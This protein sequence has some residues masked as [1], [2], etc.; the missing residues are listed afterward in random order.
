M[1]FNKYDMAINIDIITIKKSNYYLV[2]DLIVNCPI[3]FKKCRNGREM[4]SKNNVNKKY[5]VYAANKNGKWTITDGSSKKCDKVLL[6]QSWVE[7]NIPEFSNDVKYDIEMAPDIIDLED[8]EKFQDDEGN[9]V[10]IEVRGDRDFDKCYFLVK[11]VANGFG[12]KRLHNVLIDDKQG[13]YIIKSHY[14]YFNCEVDSS[15]VKK[16]IKKELFL[17]YTGILRVLFTSRNKTTEKF[18]TWATKTLFTIQMGTK[19]QKNELIADIMGVSPE[20]V[21]AV[22]SKSAST[23]PCIYLFTIGTVKNLRKTLDLDDDYHDNDCVYRFGTTK[24][25]SRRTAE[26]TSSY[27]KL[28][29]AD[30]KLKIFNFIDVQYIFKAETELKLFMTTLNMNIKYENHKELVIIPKNKLKLV[31]KQYNYIGNNYIGHIKELIDKIKEKDSLIKDKD[32]E[33]KDKD[34][35]LKDKDHE[36]ELFK[37]K[38]ENKLLKKELEIVKLQSKL[39]KINLK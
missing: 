21:K 35:E 2:D 27:N 19:T 28:K 10:E 32:H 3:F 18:I 34:H 1:I 30:V 33:L 6:L 5:F 7:K 26:H 9:I 31:E 29:G 39:N 25:L 20:A 24:E 8:N 11:D 14:M 22:F 4:L 38:V 15:N 16:T 17:T 12:L 23:L 36:M 37:S 13:G